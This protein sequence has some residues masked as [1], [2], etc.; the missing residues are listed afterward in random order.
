MNEPTPHTSA[1]SIQWTNPLFITFNLLPTWTNILSVSFTPCHAR[2]KWGQQFHCLTWFSTPALPAWLHYDSVCC[3][4]CWQVH[5]VPVWQ[6]LMATEII[7]HGFPPVKTYLK[8]NMTCTVCIYFLIS[9]SA[10]PLHLPTQWN[11][12]SLASFLYVGHWHACHTR[13]A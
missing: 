7:L 9:L 5:E 12:K 11:T 10:L 1:E 6:F 2:T 3:L 4:H 13:T 8:F